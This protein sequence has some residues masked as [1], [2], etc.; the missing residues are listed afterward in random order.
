MPTIDEVYNFQCKV[1]EPETADLSEKELKE[2]LK[3]LYAC[4]PY[5]EKKDG[6]KEPY[7]TDLDYSKKWFKC[8][9]HLLNLLTMKRQ[10]SRYKVSFWLSVTALVVSVCGVAIRAVLGG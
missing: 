9:D 10:E 6:N 5:T 8:Y 3:Q 2:M 1:F 4:F 7:A